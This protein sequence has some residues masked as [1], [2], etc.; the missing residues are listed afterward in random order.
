MSRRYRL[1]V[2]TSDEVGPHVEEYLARVA[3]R[4]HARLTVSEYDDHGDYRMEIRSRSIRR[5]G[6][7]EEEVAS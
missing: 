5:L 4:L 6:T 2:E 3:D 7:A 1:T